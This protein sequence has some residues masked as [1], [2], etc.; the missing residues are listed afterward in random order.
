MV[1]EKYTPHTRLEC[2]PASSERHSHFDKEEELDHVVL[3]EHGGGSLQRLHERSKAILVDRDRLLNSN[4]ATDRRRIVQWL[5]DE[6]E[7]LHLKDE[8]L[9]EA[10][11]LLDR[12][13]AGPTSSRIK[14]QRRSSAE[15]EPI[16]GVLAVVLSVLKMS[17]SDDE[18]GMTVREVILRIS[19]GRPAGLWQ[20][21]I[22]AEFKMCM[23]LDFKVGVPTFVDLVSRI[24]IGIVV[25]A[26]AGTNGHS[27]QGLTKERMRR[28]TAKASTPRIL[29]L[30]YYLLELSL[31][32]AH[33]ELYQEGLQP[34]VLAFAIARLALNAFGV[35]PAVCV[36]A[37]TATEREA[38]LSEEV[39]SLIPPLTSVV[40][41]LWKAPPAE[42]RVQSKWEGR[43]LLDLVHLPP[44]PDIWNLQVDH[45]EALICTPPKPSRRHSP[46]PTSAPRLA[47]PE[48]N[49]RRLVREEVELDPVT[50][51]TGVAEDSANKI[52][53]RVGLRSVKRDEDIP[54][55]SNKSTGKRKLKSDESSGSD[56]K[57]AKVFTRLRQPLL[58]DRQSNASSQISALETERLIAELVEEEMKQRKKK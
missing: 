45:V 34:I 19:G 23:K 53:S 21:V 1:V 30:S 47:R 22:Q 31:V 39:E 2:S 35:P 7:K 58:M 6:F 50:K 48:S 55:S 36:T 9:L 32:H 54:A 37:L 4:Y 12:V 26:K 41:G 27:W 51:S 17:A 11:V 25:A 15:T 20:Q 56:G 18:M 52:P 46:P 49:R 16:A 44:A 8:W 29:A 24:T 28:T 5:M 14:L 38:F 3:T 57:P 43:M 40:H 42:S 10:I 13:L 33:E